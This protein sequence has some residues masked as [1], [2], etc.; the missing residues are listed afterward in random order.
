MTTTTATS[1]SLT[2][3]VA[4][5]F[6]KKEARTLPVFGMPCSK[7]EPRK[8]FSVGNKRARKRIARGNSM[9]VMFEYA[10][11]SD[12]TMGAVHQALG[13]PH[14][15]LAKEHIDLETNEGDE[16]LTAQLQS[17]SKPNMWAAIPCTSGSPWQRLNV[18]KYGNKYKQYLRAQVKRSEA[19]F[20]RF[21]KHAEVVIEQEGHVTFEW[22]RDCEALAEQ[23]QEGTGVELEYVKTDFQAADIFTK[24]LPPHKWDHA[25]RLLGMRTDLPEELEDTRFNIKK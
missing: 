4:E 25:L 2:C 3:H 11:S 9:P 10:C 21:T 13:I 23:L 24:A 18:H 8:K 6:I 5:S 12:S 15:R 16:Q 20:A 19:L 22:P 14:V 1:T 17:C 7:K